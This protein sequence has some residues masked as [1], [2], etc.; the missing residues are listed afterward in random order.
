MNQNVVCW[1]EI[2][3]SNMDRAKKFYNAVLGTDF[4]DM[5]DPTEDAGDEPV[6]FPRPSFDAL[7]RQVKARRRQ[8]ADP[9]IDQS[10]KRIRIHG[11][12]L[13]ARQHTCTHCM[14]SSDAS[15]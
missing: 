12:I 15:F 3:V 4:T 10:N 7:E 9:V 8:P 11:R 6:R 2:Y 13:P 1:F 5:S 14:F